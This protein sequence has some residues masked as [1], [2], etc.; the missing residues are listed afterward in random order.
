ML[1]NIFFL[2]VLLISF[3]SRAANQ[4][5]QRLCAHPQ[6]CNLVKELDPKIEISSAVVFVGDHHHFEP[7]P[8]DIKS[9][10]SAKNLFHGPLALHPWLKMII[11]QRST[12][13][14][15][16]NYPLQFSKDIK[17]NF[18]KA[19]EEALA[20]FWL[21]GKTT[22]EFKE[23]YAK[24]L[25]LTFNREQCLNDFANIESE[26]KKYFKTHLSPIV[27]THDALEPLFV[28]LG[29]KI[30][31][32]KGSNHHEEVSSLAIKKLLTETK[33]QKLTWILETGF[34]LPSSVQNQIQA[35]D[36]VIKIDTNGK[37]GQKTNA[38]LTE[39]Y[40]ALIKIPE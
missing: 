27:L 24:L 13:S 36:H 4:G 3:Y 38:V 33:A 39:I 5:V 8:Q 29:A 30:I 11:H 32:L 28:S 31:S 2:S 1:K 14:E 12:N 18:P 35:K 34:Q 23:Q 20:H 15:L 7:N 21:Y 25:D 40:N 6:I 19:S 17:K 37:Y 9:L 26:L 16:K 22:C 10:L